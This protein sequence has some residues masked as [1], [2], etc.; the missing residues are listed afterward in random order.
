MQ[1]NDLLILNIVSIIFCLIFLYTFISE[2]IIDILE[3]N[4][5][6]LINRKIGSNILFM[7]DEKTEDPT[8]KKLLDAKKK[9]QIA[10]S[11]DFNSALQLLM[12]SIVAT[13]LG[14]LIYKKIV[15]F[16]KLGLSVDFKMSFTGNNVKS[17]VIDNIV[18]FI[19]IIIPVFGVLFI[20]AIVINLAQTKFNYSF[21]PLKPD[22]KKLN[23]IEG[24]KKLFSKKVLFGFVKNISKL[25]LV[26]YI[27]YSFIKENIFKIQGIALTSVNN[28]YTY[29]SELLRGF[30]IKFAIILVIVG[31]ADYVYQIYDF[32]KSLK[33]T[34]HEVKEEY[35][36]VEG[37]PLI[38]SKRRQ[39][40]KQLAMS[41]MMADVEKSTVVVTNPTHLALAIRYDDKLDSAPKLLAK[42]ADNV[43]AKIRELAK[44]KGI[45][46]VEN[47][48]LARVLF[49][50]VKIGQEIPVE[51]YEAVAEILAFVYRLEQKKKSFTKSRRRM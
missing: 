50:K 4:D 8:P 26:T 41:R 36:Q 1:Y 15:L 11:Q 10:K 12:F 14:D 18:N 38:K 49:K 37:D 25:A 39:K 33:M 40:Q 28:F 7:A 42:G 45:P 2:D 3:N 43:A 13:S 19:G 48:P 9:G 51:F 21:H 24:F 20:S 16:L 44:S 30:V 27:S 5:S 29:L 34:K 23:P 35:K 46:I 17:F 6:L 31:I 47:K 22:F 32:K